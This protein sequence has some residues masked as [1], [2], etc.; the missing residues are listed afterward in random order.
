MNVFYGTKGL[1]KSDEDDSENL[2]GFG[3]AKN[4]QIPTTFGFG[5][6]L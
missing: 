2:L 4:C 5:F 1:S 3:F 6:V